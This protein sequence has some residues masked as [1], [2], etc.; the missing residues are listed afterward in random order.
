MAMV[1]TTDGVVL[2]GIMKVSRTVRVLCSSKGHNFHQ[3]GRW[4]PVYPEGYSSRFHN[5]EGMGARPAGTE[6]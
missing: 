6:A 2:T 4:S 1:A 5:L 3:G